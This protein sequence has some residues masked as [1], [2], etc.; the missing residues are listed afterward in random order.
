VAFVMDGLGAE[1][2]DRSYSDRELVRRI[3]GYFRPHARAMAA[4]AAT[5]FTSSLLDAALPVLISVGV[6][7]VATSRGALSPGAVALFVGILVAAG[8]SWTLNYVRQRQT[9]VAVGDV[10]LDLRKDA[11]DAV[12]ARDLSFYDE[13]PSGKIVSRVTSDTQD[14]ATVVTLTLTLFSQLGQVVLV[15]AVLV[16]VNARLAGITLAVAPLVIAVALGFRAVA[17]RT[18]TQARRVVADVNANIQ[19]AVTG[20]AV[21]KAFR[22][23][24]T[25]YGVFR[26]LNARS[27]GLQ[28]RQGLVFNVIFPALTLIGALATAAVVWFG[29][30]V[31]LSGGATPGEWYLFV[32]SLSLFLFPLTGVASFWSQFQSGLSASERVFALIDATP[33]VVQTG[34]VV[35]E[36]LAGRITFRGVDFRYTDAEQVLQGFDFEI[37][38]GETVALVGHT[39]AGKSS[40][41]KLV[42]R[43]YE[44]Q[45]GTLLVDGQDLRTF[46]LAAYRRNLGIVQQT[47]FLFA[48]TV[49]DNIRYGRQT[50]TDEEV[51]A[52]A[53]RIGGGD[54][55]AVLERGLDT[56]VGEG[57][58]GIS[59]GQRQLVSLARVL[60]MCGA[61]GMAFGVCYLGLSVAPTLLVAVPLAFLAHLGG[62]AQ[63][64]LST[65]GLQRRA[66]DAIRGRILAGD[67]GI[68]TLIITLS[69]LGAGAL[70]DSLGAR[71]AIA[72]FACLSL[73]AGASYL[74]FTRGVRDRLAAEFRLSPEQSSPATP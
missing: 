29:G 14:F 58:R 71:T 69:N 38:A 17:R 42:A 36:T 8:L 4:V 33:R 6:D 32:Q 67:F 41:G 16:W 35:P 40:L 65:Y 51:V 25:V 26:D 70:A 10:V 37:A 1:A 53:G 47:P 2:Y 21:A 28:L 62:G 5:V 73:L 19:E 48:G 61:A 18:T 59:M 55:L 27:Y 11:F 54:W 57:G 56:D 22:Q 12:L 3:V 39:G 23:E 44:F 72:V 7:R 9:A 74:W 20:I 49:R 63:W 30:G 64:T 68:V 24:A 45:A 60:L 66:P 50:A 46:E 15:V 13:F 43:F 52:A 31:V 34:A